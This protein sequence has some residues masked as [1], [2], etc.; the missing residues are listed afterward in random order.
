VTINGHKEDFRTDPGWEEY[1]NRRTYETT[2]VRP[3]FDFGYC[4]THHAG[5]QGPGELGGLVFRGDCRYPDRMAYY[6]D[7]LGTLTLARPV[8][9]SGK[10]G[11]RRGVTDS[12]VLF[13]F[14]HSRDSM[15]VNPSQDSGL[16]RNFLGIVVDGPSREG[17]YFA[18]A[19]RVHNGGSGHAGGRQEPPR[20]Y[21]NGKAHDWTLEY[22]PPG[23]AGKGQ[24]TLTL[25]RQSVTLNLRESHQA[26]GAHFDRFGILTTWVDGNAQEIYFDDL[27]YTCKQD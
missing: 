12:T 18:P 25:D 23:T 3:R 21:P 24:I 10:V 5:G 7:R 2:N 1:Q 22:S 13:G 15:T 27:T 26:A 20:I 17:F 8:K 11:L 6:A 14:F 9:A 4:P 16:P 19:Y